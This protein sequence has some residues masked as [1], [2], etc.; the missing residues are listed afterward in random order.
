MSAAAPKTWQK[1]R[2]TYAKQNGT[3]TLTPA[4]VKRDKHE[5]NEAKGNR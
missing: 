2:A 5:R 1:R 3:K 4:Q